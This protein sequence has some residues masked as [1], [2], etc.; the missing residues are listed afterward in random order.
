MKVQGVKEVLIAPPPCSNEMYCMA[1][2]NAG[3]P[4]YVEKP[5]SINAAEALRMIELATKKDVPLVVAH[6]RRQQPFFKKIKQEEQIIN[7]GVK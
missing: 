5:I 7:E 1:A 2:I 4:V 6:Y 3:K